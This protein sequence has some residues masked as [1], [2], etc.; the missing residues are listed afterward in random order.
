ME[1][2]QDLSAEDHVVMRLDYPDDLPYV[3]LPDWN[4][5]KMV[6]DENIAYLIGQF[7]SDGHI[8]EGYGNSNGICRFNFNSSSVG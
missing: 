4:G 6:L 3:E 8:E 7:L 5:K 2:G 1:G